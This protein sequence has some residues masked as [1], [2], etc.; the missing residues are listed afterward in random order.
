[1]KKKS[2][3]LAAMLLATW[4]AAVT[5]IAG[6]K[7]EYGDSAWMKLDLL[8]Q[9]DFSFLDNALDED[10]FYLRRF[11]IL[12]NGQIAEGIKTFLQT[13]YSNAGKNGA[14][15]E[16]ILI[17]GWVD[18]QL[19]GSNQWLKVGLVPLPFSMEN[20]SAVGSLLGIDYNTEILKFVNDSTWRDVGAVLQGTFFDRLGYRVGTFDGYDD[21]EKN[22]DAG[23]RFTG[24]IDLAAIGDVQTSWYTQDTLGKETY[25]RAG[26]GYDYQ[27][28]A[29]LIASAGP[30]EIPVDNEAWVLDFQSGYQFND[31]LQLTVNGAWYDWDN[32]AFKGNTA[33]V[34][35]GLRYNKFIGTLKYTL[36]DPDEGSA[37]NDYTLGLHYNLK[38]NN[39]KAGV[40]YRSGDSDD[41]WLVGIQFML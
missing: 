19:F 39:L 9:V 32:S 14:D 38:A 13:D 7:W 17:D 23:L 37:V 1:M 33:F 24:R 10:D 5:V 25:L 29:T 41:W 36:Q 22:P 21:N 4:V 40:E 26:V 30:A 6:P 8:A 11:R 27:K 2:L 34:E 20:N 28:D 15:P 3:A 35:A 18:L 31:T 16:F 12:V